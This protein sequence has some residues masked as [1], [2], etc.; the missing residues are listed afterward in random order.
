MNGNGMQLRTD[1]EAGGPKC[2]PVP[3]LA[4][5]RPLPETA[6]NS[7]LSTYETASR[8]EVDQLRQKRQTDREWERARWRLVEFARTLVRWDAEQRARSTESKTPTLRHED[9]CSHT[10][11]TIQ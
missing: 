8:A 5:G 4:A 11:Q 9:R 2:V 1:Q 7:R 3:Q 6:Q 10:D